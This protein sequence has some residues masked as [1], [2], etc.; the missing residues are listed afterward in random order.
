MEPT[1]L[2]TVNE[3]K[4]ISELLDGETI[5]INLENGNYYSMNETGSIIWN[6]LANNHTLG[7]ILEHLS[8][9]FS[10]PKEELEKEL[11][12]IVSFLEQEE[13][14]MECVAD[15]ETLHEVSLQTFSEK[16]DFIIPVIQKYEDMQ[17]MLLADPIHD[18]TDSGWPVLK[19]TE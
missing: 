5:I 2:Y 6:T 15:P 4:V 7:A 12:N 1:K 9:R 14:I 19:K 10:A 18:V 8:S 13:L 17:D 16:N 11:G 3:M